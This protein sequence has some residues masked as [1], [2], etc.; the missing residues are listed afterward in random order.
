[1]VSRALRSTW[2]LIAL[3]ALALSASACSTNEYL[4]IMTSGSI[5][6]PPAE[7]VVTPGDSYLGLR[8]WQAQCRGHVFQC[9]NGGRDLICT[10]MLPLPGGPA[11]AAPAPPPAQ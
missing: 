7:I 5:G 3:G 4:P 6:C 2:G 1:M 11:P 8:S 9:S 10:E